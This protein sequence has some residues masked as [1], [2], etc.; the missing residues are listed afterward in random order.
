MRRP[1]NRGSRR[2]DGEEDDG[3]ARSPSRPQARQLGGVSQWSEEALR[4]FKHQAGGG[5]LLCIRA[6]P[7][8]GRILGQARFP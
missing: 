8:D 5:K 4:P 6:W 7:R 1:A 3:V 2:P